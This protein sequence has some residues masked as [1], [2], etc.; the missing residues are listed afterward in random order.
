MDQSMDDKNES[1]HL[2]NMYIL[3]LLSKLRFFNPYTIDTDL[4]KADT[5]RTCKLTLP[6]LTAGQS[7]L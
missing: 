6:G 3:Y 7:V 5:T 4:C 1:V 2:E